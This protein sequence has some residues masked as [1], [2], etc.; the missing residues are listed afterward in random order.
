MTPTTTPT[1]WPPRTAGSPASGSPAEAPSQAAGQPSARSPESSSSWLT[2]TSSR[3]RS[4]YSTETTRP[5]R[6]VT[7]AGPLLARPSRPAL[8]AHRFLPPRRGAKPPTPA[9]AALEL[10][11]AAGIIAVGAVPFLP[12]FASVIGCLAV[13]YGALIGG[14]TAF[15]CSRLR[16]SVLPSM[17]ALALVHVLVAP[18]LLTDVGSGL[19]AV[20]T[21]LA[22]TVTVWRDALTVPMPL[23][24]F[25][26]MTVLP[27]LVGLV[28]SALAT[29][30]ILAGR[31]VL[32]GLSL[33]LLPVVGIG[34]G[35]QEA[36][37]PTA[38]GV[39]FVAGI[40]ALWTCGSLRQRRSHVI[41]A[42]DLS[43][44]STTSGTTSARS[45]GDLGRAALRGAVIAAVLLIVTS[46]AAMALTPA[47]PASRTVVRDLFQPPLDLTEYASP[48]SLVRTL[49]PDKAHTQLMKPT[50][51]PKGGR[52]RIAAMDSY[53][54][55][56][57]H[58]GQNENGQSRFERIG[59]KTQL[60][61]SRLDGKKQ[62]S[63]L[64]I[65][66]YSFPWVPT[67]PETIRIESS[68]PR[69]SALSEG[70]YYD[71]FSSTGIA[72]S[73]LAEGDVLTERVA[74]YTPPSE[75]TL[76]KASIAQTSLGPIDQVPSSVAS[77][78]KEIVGVESNPIAQVRALQQRL[79]TSYYSDGTQSPS[80]PGHGA[81]RIASMVEADSLIGDDEQYSVL[82]MLMCRSLNIPAR[83]V[84]GFD[85]ATDGDAKTVTGE[86]VKAWVEIPFEG[87]GWVSFDVT[88][89]RDQVPQQ[90]TTQKVSN[91][92][93]NVLQ[94][95]LPN[96]DPAQL[97]PN[98]E[99]PQRNDPQDD[100]KGGLPTAVIVVGGSI[101][102][103][104]AVVGSVLGWKA[105]R[106]SRRRGRTGVGKA[107][108]AWEE[109]L[110]RARDLGR[111]PGWGVTRREAAAQL[112]PHFPQA[113][114]P[115][116]AGA[117]DTQVFSSGEPASYA[118]GE[119][120]ESSDAIVRSMGAERSR[121]GR[122][123]ARL[124]PRSL[125]HPA[126]RRSRRPRRLRS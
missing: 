103:I 11:L 33:V 105:W 10:T 12:V 19:T 13:G 50:N 61:A 94:P 44:F 84:M 95:P 86:D 51:L 120:W 23:S 22:A 77:L 89:D 69:Q 14:L 75:A 46:L 15:A 58:I 122:A 110:D 55:L 126:G 17:A 74:P 68:G 70:L 32:A 73:G 28:V 78:A 97:P 27:W 49:E 43:S 71:K 90:Q 59:D 39:L 48:L 62:T 121:L 119:L 96:E 91:P 99:D 2:A 116:F 60:T 81:A 111:V 36:V 124:S 67:M 38:L 102:A 34:W 42:L 57:A 115:R 93:P 72:T 5:A 53:D 26:G 6:S 16:L 100:D 98:Y 9:V 63:S 45:T 52:I 54:G 29:R 83:V 30:L 87:L 40:L 24:S 106:R 35:G 117:V 80:Q 41:E 56:S 76:N 18:W 47:A 64:T 4:L 125:V 20:K 3:T 88:P 92:E 114:L 65:E 118:L 8:S 123:M 113:D 101:L 108:G 37:R 107:L 31:E 1:T 21:V 7:G 82:M 104:A 79:R 66:D 112:A 109:I 85:P 25:S